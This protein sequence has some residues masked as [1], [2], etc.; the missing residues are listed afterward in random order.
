LVAIAGSTESLVETQVIGVSLSPSEDFTNGRIEEIDVKYYSQ[1]LMG[2][3]DFGLIKAE[4]RVV[5]T[6]LF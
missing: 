2:V 1:L 3:G 5:F 4:R 6:R